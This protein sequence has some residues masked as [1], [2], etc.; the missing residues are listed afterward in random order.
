MTR[1]SGSTVEKSKHL[2]LTK[3]VHTL[4]GNADRVAPCEQGGFDSHEGL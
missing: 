1:K 4:G 3:G 2:P